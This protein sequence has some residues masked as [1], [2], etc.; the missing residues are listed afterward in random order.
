MVWRLL[1]ARTRYAPLVC[2]RGLP[3]QELAE[4]RG[5]GLVQSGAHRHLDGLPIQA[6]GLAPFA[7]DA[8]QKAIHFARHLLMDR[9]SRFFSCAVQT[10]LSAS[11]GRSWQILSLTFSSWL[12]S[13]WKR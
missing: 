13:C 1:S 7:K 3:L 8:C 10:P 12:R 9:S 2:R 11:T 4:R 5:P 6:L